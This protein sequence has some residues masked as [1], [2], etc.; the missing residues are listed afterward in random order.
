MRESNKYISSIE[1]NVLRMSRLDRLGAKVRFGRSGF[2]HRNSKSTCNFILEFLSRRF[3]GEITRSWPW[4]CHRSKS[5][6]CG[7]DESRIVGRLISQSGKNIIPRAGGYP[8]VLLDFNFAIIHFLI[9]VF[10]FG[11]PCAGATLRY[12]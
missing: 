10:V 8:F 2:R 9:I 3:N 4:L 7:Y 1:C 12:A 6:S 11:K 5:T